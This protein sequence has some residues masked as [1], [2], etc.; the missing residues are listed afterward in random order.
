M[1]ALPVISRHTTGTQPTTN[2]VARLT[3][4]LSCHGC[5]L[6]GIQAAYVVKRFEE[7]KSHHQ[8]RAL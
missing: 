1:R 4:I 3:S 7:G 5:G 6:A 2:G 8:T